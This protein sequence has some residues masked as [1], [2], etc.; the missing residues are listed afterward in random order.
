MAAN[1][2]TDSDGSAAS[3]AWRARPRPLNM[4]KLE[5]GQADN[6]RDRYSD[7]SKRDDVQ[8]VPSA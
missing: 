7:E 5:F 3:S 1:D 2:V 4:P 8:K 6:Y